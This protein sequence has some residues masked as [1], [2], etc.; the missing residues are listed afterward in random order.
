MR[1]AVF[2]VA[3]VGEE[4]GAVEAVERDETEAV[5]DELVRQDGGVGYDVD[6]VDGEGGDL[7]E[8]GAAERVGEGEGGGLQD[9]VDAV[10]FGLVDDPVS[11]DPKM[12]RKCRERRA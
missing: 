10:L 3:G 11:N 9:E 1:V 8:H 6:E 12:K 5:G 4:G 2:T 7:G